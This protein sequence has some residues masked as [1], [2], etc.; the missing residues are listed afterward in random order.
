MKTNCSAQHL[1]RI[2]NIMLAVVL[3][4]VFGLEVYL[5]V[6]LPARSGHTATFQTDSPAVASASIS[7]LMVVAR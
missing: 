2:R 4:T 5:G 1:V 3:A 7:D 6:F